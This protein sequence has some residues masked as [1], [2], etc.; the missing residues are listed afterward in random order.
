MISPILILTESPVLVN[1]LYKLHCFKS[2]V[3]P[4]VLLSHVNSLPFILCS[5]CLFRAL[6]DQ[7]DGIDDGHLR[8]RRT[9]VKYLA[10]HRKE[11]EPFVEDNRSFDEHGKGILVNDK[12]IVLSD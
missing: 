12:K 1:V 4:I 2:I 9:I 10:D 8:Y 5:N 7:L 3:I 6:A 11:F